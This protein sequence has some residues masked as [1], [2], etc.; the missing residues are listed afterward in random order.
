MRSLPYITVVT[1]LFGVLLAGGMVV[2]SAQ[3]HPQQ[4]FLGGGGMIHGNVYGFD[5]YD[6]LTPIEWAPVTA[7]NGQYNFVAYSGSMG[8]YEMFVPVGI[9]NVTVVTP[10]YKAHSM[11]IAVADGS[12]SAINFYLEQS[13]VPVPEFQPS[14]F[15][16]VLFVALASV[17]L[18]KRATARRR[19]QSH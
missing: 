4:T 11:S 16:I 9:Y 10:G 14:A 12:S 6:Q 18:A 5:M 7:S 17:L 1:L 2:A 13:G 8:S 19:K 15:A 3:S